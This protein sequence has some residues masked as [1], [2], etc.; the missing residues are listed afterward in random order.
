MQFDEGE[1]GCAINRHEEEELAL[2]LTLS[3]LHRRVTRWTRC[4]YVDVELSPEAAR[5]EDHEA[6]SKGGDRQQRAH[7]N[8]RRNR[9]AV[10]HVESVVDAGGPFRRIKYAAIRRDD[11]V[12]HR[13]AHRAAA[14]RVG[15][16]RARLSQK[17][18]A[19]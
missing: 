10:A 12:V 6:F 18:S 5:G 7:A 4:G 11:P 3:S 8:R 14:E 16:D 17:T 2:L 19:P 13:L 1:L 9:R 15:D